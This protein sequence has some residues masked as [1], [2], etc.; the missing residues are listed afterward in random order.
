[1][2]HMNNKKKKFNKILFNSHKILTTKN[3]N[4]KKILLKLKFKLKI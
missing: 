2:I 1:M 4:N 3:I